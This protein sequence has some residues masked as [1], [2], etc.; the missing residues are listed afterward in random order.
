[1][2]G[3]S[4]NYLSGK[5]EC[6]LSMRLDT[7]RRRAFYDFVMKRVCPALHAIEWNDSGDGHDRE[8]D[9]IDAVIGPRGELEQTI[10]D[11]RAALENLEH[12]LARVERCSD[13][14]SA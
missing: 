2:S 5:I 8:D 10:H 1:M 11:A 4:M 12:A 9:L 3:G 6:D 7:P 14:P 13:D